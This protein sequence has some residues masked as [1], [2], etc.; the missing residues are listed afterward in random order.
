MARHRRRKHS[1]NP[2]TSEVQRLSIYPRVQVPKDDDK[3]KVGDVIEVT[4]SDMDNRGRGIA[5]Y[6][7]YKII[8]Y[9][10]G[11]GSRVKARIT[12]VAGDSIYAEVVDTITESSIEY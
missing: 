5:N 2:Y 9:D 7:G 8:V 12:K 1:W 10:A 11:V 4:V 3:P 6:K